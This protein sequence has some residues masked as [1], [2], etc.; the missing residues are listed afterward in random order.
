RGRERVN[1]PLA[2]HRGRA[3]A[4]EGWSPVLAPLVVYQAGT[5]EIGGLFPLLGG[6]PTPAVGARIGYDVLSGSAF[7]CHPVE[8]V[9]HG[10]CTNPNMVVF[11]EP[12][13][14][15]S[16]TVV[17]FLLRMMLFGVRT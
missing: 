6:A 2:P 16:S 15:K 11:G 1:R 5:H 4:G 9:L 8:W 10:L 17:A 3:R 14:G 12:G 13:K 7:Y